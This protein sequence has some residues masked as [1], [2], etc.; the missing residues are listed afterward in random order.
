MWSY[1]LDTDGLFFQKR[2]RESDEIQN[3]KQSVKKAEKAINIVEQRYPVHHEGEVIKVTG[4]GG[5]S[6]DLLGSF[7]Q[8]GQM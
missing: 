8:P 2:H 4:A 5:F 1:G 3:E 6:E 7:S